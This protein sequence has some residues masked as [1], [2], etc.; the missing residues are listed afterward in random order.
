MRA[1]GGWDTVVGMT[2][3]P[4]PPVELVAFPEQGRRFTSSSR[5]RFADTGP[6]R[7]LRLDALARLVQDAGT[8]DLADAGMDPAS[9]WVLRRVAVWVPG[10]WPILG[11][12]VTVT[13]F[14]AGLAE[15]W[16]ERRST[17]SSASGTIEV[18]AVWIFL[19]ATGRPG[20]LSSDFVDIYAASAAGRK[21][22]S[23]LHHPGPPDPGPGLE[24]R[25]WPL[26]SS[27]FDAFGHVNNAAWWMPIE[28]ELARHQLIPRFAE[29]EFRSPVAVG[30]TVN[31]AS[32]W[33]PDG[34]AMWVRSDDGVAVSARLDR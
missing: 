24:E 25:E 20:R 9:P 2:S 3:S 1:G 15:R 31:L 13:T 22:S 14:C 10:G 17:V 4:I 19:D 27:D 21:T 32:Q 7:R 8:E 5:V 30:E 28:D 29:V 16:G 26:R 34:L 18:S 6:G 12:P 33:G 11:D 23:R